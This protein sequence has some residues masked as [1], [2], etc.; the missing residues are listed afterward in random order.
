M[1]ACAILGLL[2]LPPVASSA[3][4]L[5]N[6][7][8][9]EQGLGWSLYGS[10]RIVGEEAHS[11]SFCLAVVQEKPAWSG[12][13]QE[14][15]L[16]EGAKRIRLTGWLKSVGVVGG[17]ESWEVARLN[18]EFRDEGGKLVGGYQ[19]LAAA[20]R[21]DTP[22]T[23]YEREFPVPK[24]ARSVLVQPALGN[25]S[26]K[27]FYDDLELAIFDEQSRPLSGARKNGP[28]DEGRWYEWPAASP[29]WHFVDWSSLL[30]P[31]AGRHGFLKVQEGRLVFEDGTPARFWGTNFVGSECFPTKEQAEKSARRL[32]R[33]GC[34]LVRLHHMDAPWARPNI[35]GNAR[36]TRSLDPDALDR[37]DYWIFQL[38]KQGIYIFLDFL[39]HREFRKEDG[40]VH[41]PP[42]LGGKQVAFFSEPLI[43]LQEEYIR[44][45][46]AHRNPY[47]GLTY[48]EEPAVVGSEFINESS[49][50]LHFGGD[51]LTEPYRREVQKLWEKSPYGGKKRRRAVFE[52]D[53]ERFGGLK[54]REAGDADAT[55]RFWAD[56]EKKYFLRMQS[57]A[58]AA[59]C[60]YPLAGSNFP[61]PILAMLWT[62]SLLD[63]TAANAYFAHPEVWK[64]PGGWSQIDRA[65]FDTRSQLK[66]PKDSL[67]AQLAW[68]RLSGKPFIV[69]EWNHCFPNEYLL[70]A[71]PL[72]AAYAR[73]Q[74]WD[75]VL[76]FASDHAAL[77]ADRL[78]QINV[79]RHPAHVAQWVM[80]A[81]LF[82]RGD[83]QEAR[84]TILEEL[85]QEDVFRFPSFSA[86]VKERFDLVFRSKVAKAFVKQKKQKKEIGLPASS[87]RLFDSDTGELHWDAKKGF[88][89]INTPRTQGFL[90]F[91]AKETI[92]FPLFEM[93]AENSFYAFFL[94]SADG[95]E[96]A[97]SRKFYI[98]AA[99][100]VKMKDQQYNESRAL[101]EHM[102]ALP[103]LVQ[104]L[105]GR[106]RWKGE[107]ELRIFPLTPKGVGKPLEGRQ[108][109]R[110]FS[111]DFSSGRSLVYEV[112]RD[113]SSRN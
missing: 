29:D 77:G 71:A 38:K 48:A 60:R 5:K 84:Q 89:K 24:E 22:W 80:A 68:F 99:T 42:E 49:A 9:E 41:P 40:V 23:F 85:D 53:W 28:M 86:F 11:G 18:V 95:K 69:T 46:M 50:F 27:V 72:L 107:G 106:F 112:R 35:F 75:G 6:G 82:L 31:P 104:V 43:R 111:V 79:N 33:M 74:G 19:P 37:L 65:P 87:D 56:I 98:V 105:E 44:Q 58:R 102:G 70:E 101:V 61:V 30:D 66:N 8:F 13:E 109:S 94:V 100:P 25:A 93:R 63:F 10:A 45:L 103:I 62:N 26:G 36:T 7:G 51:L 59:G 108:D 64:V 67:P 97:E 57:A 52:Q 16:P 47:T 54:M 83:V 81:P 15:F 110:G 12:A 76:Q 4:V 39:V 96:L 21:G 90:G 78:V 1:P 20:V 32:A 92:S 17:K 2:A 34:N 14:I 3:S 55:V 73:L 88:W 113:E 91:C